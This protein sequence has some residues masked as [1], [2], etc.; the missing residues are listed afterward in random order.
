MQTEFETGIFHL[1]GY[2][3]F[4]GTILTFSRVIITFLKEIIAFF[5]L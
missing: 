4:L 2:S 5:G 3:Y 1:P